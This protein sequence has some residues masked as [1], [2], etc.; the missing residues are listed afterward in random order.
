MKAHIHQ[1]KTDILNI[2]DQL[3]KLLRPVLNVLVLNEPFNKKYK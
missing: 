3:N 1:I 2:A